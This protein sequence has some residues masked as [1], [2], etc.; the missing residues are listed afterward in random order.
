MNSLSTL[1]ILGFLSLSDASIYKLECHDKLRAC[2]YLKHKGL[3]T[4]SPGFI[5]P[6]C[7]LSCQV[8]QREKIERLDDIHAGNLI[9]DPNSSNYAVNSSSNSRAEHVIGTPILHNGEDVVQ[10]TYPYHIHVAHII[11]Y[12]KLATCG[13]V[14]ISAEWVATA[15]HCVS[16]D[17]RISPIDNFFIAGGVTSVYNWNSDFTYEIV[18]IVMHPNYNINLDS[19]HQYDMALLKVKPKHNYS[20]DPKKVSPIKLPSTED[21][22]EPTDDCYIL[23]AGFTKSTRGGVLQQV[24]ANQFVDYSDKMFQFPDF[25]CRGD[26][27]SA[28]V[29]MHFEGGRKVPKLHGIVST[30][31]RYGPDDEHCKSLPYKGKMYISKTEYYADWIHQYI[32][33]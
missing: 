25:S 6:L 20:P 23:G 18:H 12:N 10:K 29:C 11:G 16:V 26:S 5:L 8:C 13:G 14:L 32:T 21:E 30:G 1:L 31:D 15:A 28:Y 27:G 4:D 22:F 3:C 7:P 33:G 24:V 19:H 17:G 2:P 9:K